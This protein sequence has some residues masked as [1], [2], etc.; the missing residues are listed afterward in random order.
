MSF[1]LWQ[2]LFFRMFAAVAGAAIATEKTSRRLGQKWFSIWVGV[3]VVGVVTLS[4]FGNG[5]TGV[6]ALV[7]PIAYWLIL[8]AFSQKL[9]QRARD[10]GY[11]KSMCYL[12]AIPVLGLA[13]V[14][15]LLFMPSEPQRG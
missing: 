5:L 11:E 13:L 15:M 7:A 1:T 9:V 14:A 12:F 3:I 10:A 8:F 6:A 2:I 4:L